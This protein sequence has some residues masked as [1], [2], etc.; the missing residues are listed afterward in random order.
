MNTRQKAIKIIEELSEK[1]LLIAL[2]ILEQL[3]SGDKEVDKMGEVLNE[4]LKL[5]GSLEVAESAFFDWDNEEDSVYEKGKLKPT[6]KEV[7]KVSDE[8]YE[9]QIWDDLDNEEVD[10]IYEGLYFLR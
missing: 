10:R 9:L 6:K 1:K 5:L 3:A 8:K 4:N 7:I 2:C